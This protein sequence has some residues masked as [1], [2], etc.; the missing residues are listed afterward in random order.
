MQEIERYLG[1]LLPFSASEKNALPLFSSFIFPGGG[2]I[3]N[4]SGEEVF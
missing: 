2:E 1:F 4:G 3:L